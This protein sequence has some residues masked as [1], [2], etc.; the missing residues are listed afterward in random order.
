M[1]L[2]KLATA[3]LSLPPLLTTNPAYQVLLV[4]VTVFVLVV[5][6][7]SSGNVL[8]LDIEYVNLLPFLTIFMYW[9]FEL[10][11]SPAIDVAPDFT[12][13]LSLYPH[14]KAS[15]VGSTYTP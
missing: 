8:S 12:V 3:E 11:V 1:I 4:L 9:F 15:F 10:D 13:T 5:I 7:L 2:S 14:L 6:V